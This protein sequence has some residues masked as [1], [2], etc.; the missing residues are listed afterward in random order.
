MKFRR[1]AAVV[2]AVVPLLASACGGIPEGGD[3]E[4]GGAEQGCTPPGGGGGAPSGAGDDNFR[5][6]MV[7]HG[8]AAD[9]FWSVV[10]NGARDAA[11]DM[12]VTVEYQAPATFDAAEMSRMVDTMV[13]TKPDGLI[14]S[15]PFPEA[16][17]PG[18]RQAIAD[19]I[20][21]IS[22]NSGSDVFERLGILAHIGQTE[23][24]AGKIAGETMAES[25]V[26][27]ALCINQ[28]VGNQ[29]LDQRCQGF[30]EG[31]GAKV[32]VV[33]V[34]IADPAGAEAAVG[35]ELRRSDDV[36]GMLALGP[37]GA[38]PALAALR[39]T[40]R[41]A[42]VQLATFDLSAEVLDAIES[43][44]MTFAIDQAQYLQGYMPVVLMTEY[45]KT[46]AIP[47]GGPDHVIM[48]GPQ[49]VTKENAAAVKDFQKQG[50]R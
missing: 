48:T 32:K 38:T 27:N 16:L 21:V 47:L 25:G 50:V 49:L 33:P 1:F 39:G 31:L 7:T 13:A 18:I 5:F 28:E 37:T 12:G 20:P 24:E 44:E 11:S 2:A 46:G 40:D 8:Q 23:F 4:A 3:A 42:D 22:I 15:L 36:N 29:A 19:C 43:G 41:V 9:P 10:S 35:N 45:L 17:A 14:V 6:V 30:E 26:T 34:D